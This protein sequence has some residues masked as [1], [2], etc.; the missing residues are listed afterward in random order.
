MLRAS[1]TSEVQ[2]GAWAVLEGATMEYAAV[3][4]FGWPKK[5]ITTRPYAG[6]SPDDIKAIETIAADFLAGIM[7]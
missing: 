4:Q 7:R 2:G 1:I 6:V 3:H 5:N